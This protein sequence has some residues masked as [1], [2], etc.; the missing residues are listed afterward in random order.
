[1]ACC[2]RM[3]DMV[4]MLDSVL[5]TLANDA[6]AQ[7][8][9]STRPEITT[10]ALTLAWPE[11]V[12]RDLAKVS[13]PD[14]FDPRTGL[15]E[16][17]VEPRWREALFA[18]RQEVSSRVRRRFPRVAG[19]R[20]VTVDEG[21]VRRQAAGSTDGR[22]APT[23]DTTAGARVPEPA[24]ADAVFLDGRTAGVHDPALRRS[25]HELI[26]AVESRARTSR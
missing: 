5:A 12:G 24:P 10:N 15:V 17:G 18:L 8:T 3:N 13:R 11:I 22:L 6:S 9:A 2:L 1:V 20:F 14:R 4:T 19:V 7:C 21:S 26:L 25:L 16:V 23:G